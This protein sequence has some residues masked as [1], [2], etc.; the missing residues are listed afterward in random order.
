MQGESE[1]PRTSQNV[2][3]IQKFTIIPS[4]FL[5]ASVERGR[6]VYPALICDIKEKPE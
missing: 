6:P 1:F 4:P 5:S 3:L 2:P